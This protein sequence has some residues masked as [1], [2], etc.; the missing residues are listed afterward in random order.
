VILILVHVGKPTFSGTRP[1]QDIQDRHLRSAC[2]KSC[3]CVIA[4]NTRIVLAI[5]SPF[6][7]TIVSP[8][9]LT[10]PLSGSVIVRI[11]ELLGSWILCP[12][13][14]VN[15]PAHVRSLTGS[16]SPFAP[17]LSVRLK[18][19]CVGTCSPTGGYD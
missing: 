7:S 14:F 8:R 10:R 3:T 13:V 1:N 4:H 16:V 17:C 6:L 12:L 5:G 9:S 18:R 2:S 15:N 19:P 11:H